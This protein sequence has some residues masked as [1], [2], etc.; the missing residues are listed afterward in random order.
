M[1]YAKV[2]KPDYSTWAYILEADVPVV[3]KR[4]ASIE[5]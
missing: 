4:C 3:F 1:W 5:A 2:K